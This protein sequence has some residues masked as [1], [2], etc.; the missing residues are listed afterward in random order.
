M[1]K[2]LVCLMAILM[3]VPL[4]A[5]CGEDEATSSTSAGEDALLTTPIKDMGGE[6]FRVLCHDF[7]SSIVD[8]TGEVLYSEEDPSKVDDAKKWVIDQVEAAYNCKIDGEVIGD[9][10]ENNVNSM[11]VNQVL[12]TTKDFHVLFD[13]LGRTARN[14]VPQHIIDLNSVST[15]DLS[16]PWWDQNAVEDLSIGGKVYFTMGDINT[17]DNNGTWCV[18]FNKKL[19][20]KY[21][22]EEDLYKLASEGKWTYD[23]FVELC[24]SQT[25]THDSNGDNVLDEKDTWAFGTETYNILIHLISAGEKIAQKD[26]DDLPYLTLSESTQKTYSILSKVLDF[27][28]DGQTV[29]IA[30]NYGTKYPDNP[31]G[32]TVHKAFVEGRE[33]FYMCGL[34][35]VASFRE[36]ED[37]FGILPVPKFDE[38]QDRYYHSVS[39]DNCT[40]MSIP[41]SFSEEEAEDIG[42]IL[43]ALSELSM[44][45][46]TPEY[47]EVQLKTRYARDNE[48]EEMLDIIFGTRT[49]DLGATYDWGGMLW[50]YCSLSTNFQSRFESVLD[51]AENELN[52]KVGDLLG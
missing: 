51:K 25:I 2:F 46:V 23:K 9:T 11:I 49:F 34:I 33:L 20:A 42:L 10:N 36:M 27:Y 22:A 21:F 16:K 44:K 17:Y 24:T 26:E 19:A 40:V 18:L 37:E 45:K 7:Y 12:S 35:H 28:N 30:N 47:Y 39:T 8:F 4:M 5:A 13:K 15:I 48:S 3:L 32:E 14:L 52:D 29:M 38:S 6:E 50:T 31:W 41:A 43:S 1:K